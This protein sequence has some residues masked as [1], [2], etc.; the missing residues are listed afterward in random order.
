MTD[1]FDGVKDIGITHIEPTTDEELIKPSS[2]SPTEEKSEEKPTEPKE[3][4]KEPE[5]KEEAIDTDKKPE[6]KP[7]EGETPRER[8]L[9]LQVEELRGKNRELLAKD[10]VKIDSKKPQLSPEKEKELSEFNP[11]EIKTFEK[12]L[13]IMA[14][15]KGYVKKE[16][17]EIRN[18]QNESQTVLNDFMESHTE[19]NDPILW[20]RLKSE[21]GLYRQ[22]TSGRDLKKILEKAHETVYNIKPASDIKKIEAQKEKISVASHSGQSP[23]GGSGNQ[24]A[25]DPSLKNNLKGF[26][27]EEIE[28]LFGKG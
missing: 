15:K 12:I 10:L 5:K 9:R 23:K 8:A 20:D 3:P 17:V 26:S 16:E 18:L 13:D 11:E 2:E 24:K 25:I 14:E 4:E 19:Y 7:V 1:D 27:D 28:D 6:P 21:V 22:P